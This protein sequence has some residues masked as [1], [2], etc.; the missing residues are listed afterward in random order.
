M[1]NYKR[2]LENKSLKDIHA[3]AREEW[4]KYLS[5]IEIED[6]DEEKKKTF[7]S[8]LYRVFL[9]PRKFYEI[10]ENGT[11]VHRNTHTGEIVS[12]V[13]Y[14]DNGFWDTYR[15]VYPLLS[16]LDTDAYAEMAEGF[17]NCYK[18]CGWLPKW[19]CPANKNCMPGMLVEATLA[20]A[21]VKDIVSGELA[22]GMLEAMLKDGECVSEAMGFGRKAL[23]EYRKYGYV[24]QA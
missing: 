19:L 24:P 18:D 23:A 16:L 7:Y 5:R 10:N 12:G 20:D 4:E 14:V 15:T 17:Y 6:P 8:C 9:W 11:A 1:L 21:I 22:E 3:L 13:Y 2:E